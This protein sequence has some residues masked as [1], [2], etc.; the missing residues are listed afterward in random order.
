MKKIMKRAAYFFLAVYTLYS[1]VS[2]IVEYHTTSSVPMLKCK[3]ALYGHPG[4]ITEEFFYVKLGTYLI[5]DELMTNAVLKL[6]PFERWNLTTGKSFTTSNMWV[7][8]YPEKKELSHPF[9][10]EKAL[11]E[12]GFMLPLSAANKLI[13]MGQL[14]SPRSVFDFFW[15]NREE[16][17]ISYRRNDA[18]PTTRVKSIKLNTDEQLQEVLTILGLQENNE[19][20]NG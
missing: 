3:N 11:R 13:S 2:L 9:V 8:W 1:F 18:L 17:V 20:Q 15:V 12:V 16:K 14:S 19:E 6:N 4:F 10:L 5:A 7:K